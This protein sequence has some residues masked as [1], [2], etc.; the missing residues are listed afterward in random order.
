MK[1]NHL[2]ISAITTIVIIACGGIEVDFA[3]E[4][5]AQEEQEPESTECACLSEPGPEGPQGER[6]PAGEQGQ[7]GQRGEQGP[8]G[9]TGEAGPPGEKGT[10]GT[11]GAQGPQGFQGPAGPA[12]ADGELDTS[13][14]YIVDDVQP[15]GN[16]QVT[17][18]SA[19]AACADGDVLLSGG[20]SY[21]D[22]NFTSRLTVNMPFSN[23]GNAPAYWLCDV[24]SGVASFIAV[25]ARAVCLAQ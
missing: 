8:Q 7:R 10:S 23:G 1:Q 15:F 16:T 11:P 9:L 17:T 25:T 13:G 2:L 24:R 20:C 19:A 3:P 14:I 22:N 5:N 18:K 4:A 21:G 12:G 6:G